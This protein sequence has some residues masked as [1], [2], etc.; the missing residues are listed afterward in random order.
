MKTT[1]SLLIV[2]G[3]ISL[4]C[5]N[6]RSIKS[7]QNDKQLNPISRDIPEWYSTSGFTQRAD[8]IVEKLLKLDSLQNGFDSLQI[9]IWIDCG[10]KMCSL[11]K[12]EKK[13]SNWSADFYSYN[14]L[15]SE[16]L[17]FKIENLR[18]QTRSPKSGW[19]IFTSD[20][21]KSNILELPDHSKYLPKYN[22]PSD[23]DRVKVEISTLNKYRLYVYP[24]L[25]LNSNIS[26]GPGKLNQAL[27]L[28]EKEFNY[29]RPCQDST[30][31]N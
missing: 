29:K 15:Y 16:N 30:G 28:I 8:K 23:A 12:L 7:E 27:K 14:I 11:I 20:L 5:H 21:I 17:S 10:N 3:V 25:G 2:T 31:V 9:R 4:C 6:K 18:V 19:D 13:M 24:E 22:I 26:D 1:L